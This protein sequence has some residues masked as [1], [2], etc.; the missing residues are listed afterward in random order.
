VFIVPWLIASLNVAVMLASSATP[1]ESRTGFVE[2]TVGGITSAVNELVAQAL[3][4]PLFF[5]NTRQ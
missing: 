3:D 1:V 2:I 5:A 4:P